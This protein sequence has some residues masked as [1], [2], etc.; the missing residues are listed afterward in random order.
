MKRPLVFSP[1]GVVSNIL[2]FGI[3]ISSFARLKQRP[4]E[5]RDD[6]RLNKVLCKSGDINHACKLNIK[7]P[8]L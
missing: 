5:C 2:S 3:V 6:I 4:N 8:R 7:G 1:R